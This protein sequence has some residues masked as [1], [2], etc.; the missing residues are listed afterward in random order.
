MRI[1]GND[2]AEIMS[3][4]SMY[5]VNTN[6]PLVARLAAWLTEL[7]KLQSWLYKQSMVSSIYFHSFSNYMVIC[8]PY[9]LGVWIWGSQFVHIAPLIFGSHT[10]QRK[11]SSFAVLSNLDVHTSGTGDC[12][13]DSQKPHQS[14]YWLIDCFI[15]WA[16]C[17][18]VTLLHPFY[19]FIRDVGKASYS[20][21]SAAVTSNALVPYKIHYYLLCMPT[22]LCPHS[23][24]S[25]HHYLFTPA[26]HHHFFPF[27]DGVAGFEATSYQ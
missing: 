2:S 6:T 17:S 11:S 23:Y 19:L 5:C 1:W 4:T 22:N 9:V 26:K 10:G 8:W 27:T 20:R 7:T 24:T 18:V 13:F 25:L 12:D 3:K 14:N 15:D 21:L 16:K